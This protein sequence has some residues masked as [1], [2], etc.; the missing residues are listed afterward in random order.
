VADTLESCILSEV[1]LFRDLPAEQLSKIGA[2]RQALFVQCP[3][4]KLI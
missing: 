2:R 1:A 4:M 3:G